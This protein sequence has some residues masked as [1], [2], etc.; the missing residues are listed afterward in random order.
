MEL[1]KFLETL[2]DKAFMN[3]W[4]RN[5]INPYR[6]SYD[7]FIA[8]KEKRT[9]RLYFLIDKE[10]YHYCISGMYLDSYFCK[11][12]IG[13]GFYPTKKHYNLNSL[14]YENREVH[15]LEFYMERR[16]EEDRS[17]EKVRETNFY[18][19]FKAEEFYD[20]NNDKNYVKIYKPEIIE[21]EQNNYDDDDE[22]KIFE[23]VNHNN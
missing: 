3:Y 18:I 7:S 5:Q 4:Y 11:D 15:V 22:N 8:G 6:D 10:N 12:D 17:I 1:R 2:V 16:V 13:Y 23:S 21:K 14:D 20:T 9:G 19:K